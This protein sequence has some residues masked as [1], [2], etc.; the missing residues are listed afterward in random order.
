VTLF[1][2]RAV[3]SIA[4]VSSPVIVVLLFGAQPVL[5]AQNPPAPSQASYSSTENGSSRPARQGS[6]VT[7][8]QPGPEDTC[9]FSRQFGIGADLP[10]GRAPAALQLS[11]DQSCRVIV[12]RISENSPTQA[13]PPPQD[14]TAAPMAPSPAQ[15]NLAVA[16][17]GSAWVKGT[18]LEQFGVTSTEVY[19][20]MT[21]YTDYAGHVSNPLGGSGYCYNSS[22]PGWSRK[23]CYYQLAQNGTFSVGVAVYA[24]WTNA[25]CRCDYTQ[26]G[27]V[28]TYYNG[29]YHYE[30]GLTQG[31]L[32]IYWTMQCAGYSRA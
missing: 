9:T 31:S 25:F 6:V 10:R 14:G 32:P 15:S 27:W 28:A 1:A 29:A 22:F 30:C 20:T 8:G 18:V 4:V 2:S 11:I 26:Y 3:R 23:S 12:T 16:N 7:Q 19:Q 21:Y 24:H 13:S 17:N 5:S